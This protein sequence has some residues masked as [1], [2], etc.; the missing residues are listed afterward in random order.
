MFTEEAKKSNKTK[1]LISAATAP[2]SRMNS[3]D[4]PALNK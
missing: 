4:I 2:D 3:L 1:L